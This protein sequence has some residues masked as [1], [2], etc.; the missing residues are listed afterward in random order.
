MADHIVH[1]HLVGVAAEAEEADQILD[2]RMVMVVHTVQEP[3][4]SKAMGAADHSLMA[5]GHQKS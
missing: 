4:R 2:C 3:R 5:M 1:R